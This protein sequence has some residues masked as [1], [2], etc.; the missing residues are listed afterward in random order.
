[1][2]L[3]R[4]N[5][6]RGLEKAQ[7]R[8]NSFIDDMEKG[9]SFEMGGFNPRV[10]ITEDDKNLYVHAEMPGIPKDNVKIS[11]NDDMLLT[12][13]GKKK[14]EELKEEQSYVR[15]ERAYGEFSR[16]FVLPENIDVDNINAKYD[17]GVLELTLP[18][19]EPPKPKEV[20]VKID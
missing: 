12:I 6:M 4:F 7:R 3:V 20:E 19:V 11:V 17:N 13:K 9:V 1:M 18:K 10:D 8:F 15:A 16:S 2:T 14:K 5:P